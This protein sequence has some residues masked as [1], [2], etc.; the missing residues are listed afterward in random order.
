MMQPHVRQTGDIDGF[1]HEEPWALVYR[2]VTALPNSLPGGGVVDC[3]MVAAVCA[4]LLPEWTLESGAFGWWGW[5][6][7]WLRMGDVVIDPYPWCV[8]SGPILVY[9]GAINSPWASLY[10]A[11]PEL[12]RRI[13]KPTGFEQDVDA[14]EEAWLEVV[15]AQ[16]KPEA[17]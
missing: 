16:D 5:P 17:G 4:R 3:H 7:S 9:V 11:S 15:A 13:D 14:L 12:R 6:H 1:R 8:A 2:V 10:C